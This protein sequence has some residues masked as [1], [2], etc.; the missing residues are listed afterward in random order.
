MIFD[1][2]TVFRLVDSVV[3]Y[4]VRVV[5]DW[6]RLERASGVD[7]ETSFQDEDF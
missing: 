5:K 2:S 3:S 1:L 4:G 7:N 6:N